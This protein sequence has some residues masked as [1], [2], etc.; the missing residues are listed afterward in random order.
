MEQVRRPRVWFAATHP[1][2]PGSPSV[3]TTGDCLQWLDEAQ[4]KAGESLPDQGRAECPSSAHG[5]TVPGTEK[6][7]WSAGWRA[8]RSQDARPPQGGTTMVAP[9]GAPFPSLFVRDGKGKTAYPAPQRI[10]ALSRGCLTIAST[11]AD[12]PRTIHTQGQ[13]RWTSSSRTA[14]ARPL[15]RVIP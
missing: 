3:P 8:R 13:N 7:Q 4:T 5:S 14:T 11:L 12:M 6:P 10:R 9:P 15:T 1:G 2:G